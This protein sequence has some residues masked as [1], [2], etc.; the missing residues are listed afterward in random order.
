MR[1]ID[2][3]AAQ[4]VTEIRRLRAQRDL[5]LLRNIEICRAQI[6]PQRSLKASRW[7][8]LGR[9]LMTYS[10]ILLMLVGCWRVLQIV[11]GYASRVH[12][13]VELDLEVKRLVMHI[14]IDRCRKT[15]GMPVFRFWSGQLERCDPLPRR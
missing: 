12:S 4:A 1:T 15:G 10:A 3:R 9:L 5:L 14:D 8:V 2:E 7:A 6:S 11:H 13:A